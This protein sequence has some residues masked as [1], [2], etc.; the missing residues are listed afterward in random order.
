MLTVDLTHSRGYL[1]PG[2]ITNHLLCNWECVM[3]IEPLKMMQLVRRRRGSVAIEHYSIVVLILAYMNSL[4]GVFLGGGGFMV[5]SATFNNISVISQRSVLLVEKTGG[6]G[7]NHRPVASHL[8]T[9]SHNVGHLALVEIRTHNTKSNY[10][11]I[12][13]TTVI[14][15]WTE[16]CFQN[17][18]PWMHSENVF[19]IPGVNLLTLKNWN[20]IMSI[21]NKTLLITYRSNK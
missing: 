19:C 16:I 6:L 11:T 5:L 7:E 21:W 1:Q 10:H 15:I 18:E 17:I 9:L 8:Q 13:A 4:V 20:Q 2:L 12:T 3:M 14:H